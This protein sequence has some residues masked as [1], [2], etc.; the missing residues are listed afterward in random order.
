MSIKPKCPPPKD[1]DSQDFQTGLS[2][3]NVLSTCTSSIC[4][5]LYGDWPQLLS[6]QQQQPINMIVIYMT[7]LYTHIHIMFFSAV[8]YIF[9]N[10]C[11]IGL[12]II[13]EGFVRVSDTKKLVLTS[14]QILFGQGMCICVITHQS[15]SV[16]WYYSS[17]TQIN[18]IQ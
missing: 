16:Y 7:L 17:C 3:S 12:R 15:S 10:V 14:N 13:C 8:C 11:V 9:Y 6:N 2:H 5:Y 1:N 18:I 4:L